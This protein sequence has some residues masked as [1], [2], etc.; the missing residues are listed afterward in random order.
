[1]YRHKLMNRIII[2]LNQLAELDAKDQDGWLQKH[3]WMEPFCQALLTLSKEEIAA[4]AVL[5][6]YKPEVLYD[7]LWQE[8]FNANKPFPFKDL[9]DFQ[10]LAY[11]DPN[12]LT[13][14]F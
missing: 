1:M 14:N 2:R 12:P 7:I 13:F 6:D 11:N 8:F 5:C 3:E 9:Q 10:N 4:A